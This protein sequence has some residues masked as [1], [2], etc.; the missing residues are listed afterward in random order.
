LRDTPKPPAE[1]SLCTLLWHSRGGGNPCRFS[2]GHAPSWPGAPGFHN[3]V[4]NPQAP[5]SWGRRKES[6]DIPDPGSILLH[7]HG[8]GRLQP[9]WSPILGGRGKKAGDTPDPGREELHPLRV[10]DLGFGDSPSVALSSGTG[11]PRP[12]KRPRSRRAPRC[13]PRCHR[14]PTPAA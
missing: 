7:H 8:V 1:T 5:H 13:L 2:E 11:W 6:G 14:C 3:R 9:P 12:G 4:V 10:S